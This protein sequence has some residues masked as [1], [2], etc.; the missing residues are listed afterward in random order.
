MKNIIKI[1]LLLLAVFLSY[2]IFNEVNGLVNFKEQKIVRY[3][4]AVA[5]LEDVANAQRLYKGFHG[6][7]TDNL[8]TLKDYINNGKILMINRRD[9]SGYVRGRGGIDVMKNFTITD[10]IL[11]NTSVKDSIFGKRSLENFGYVNVDGKKL[12][13]EMYASYADRIVGQD[14]TNI[15]RDHFF[16]AWVNKRDVLAG[17]GDNYIARE[18]EDETSQIKSDVIQV[19]SDTRPTLEGNWASELDAT[20]KARRDRQAMRESTTASK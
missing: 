17:L 3:T 8:D 10:T 16:K 1:G 11:S 4:D 9:S 7:Y 6:K 14:S 12:P 19:G 2:M 20:L 15:Q 13:I 18:M 5:Q